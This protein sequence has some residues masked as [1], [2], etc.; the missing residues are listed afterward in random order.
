MIHLLLISYWIFARSLTINI[1]SAASTCLASIVRCT[2][3]RRMGVSHWVPRRVRS[4][5]E[6]GFPESCGCP[7]NHLLAFPWN[8][9]SSYWDTPTYGNARWFVNLRE[10]VVSDLSWM[11]LHDLGFG[12]LNLDESGIFWN[13]LMYSGVSHSQS[14]KRWCSELG[15][16]QTSTCN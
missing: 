6:H 2:R 11:V 12:I 9:P 15:F 14:T 4:V 3:T 7:S 16:C 8:S 5:G 1:C 10:F 13:I